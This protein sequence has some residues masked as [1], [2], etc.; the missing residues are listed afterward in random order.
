MHTLELTLTLVSYL[1]IPA[2]W[3]TYLYVIVK[4]ETC[5]STVLSGCH[6]SDKF[7][8]VKHNKVLQAKQAKH[9]FKFI[10]FTVKC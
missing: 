7:Q 8:Y 1:K 9:L 10:L 4:L 5:I 6:V 3:T 2:Q